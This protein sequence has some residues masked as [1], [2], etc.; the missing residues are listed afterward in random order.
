MAGG[1]N[2]FGGSTG[3]DLIPSGIL[4]D[5]RRQG[6]GIQQGQ[7]APGGIDQLFGLAGGLGQ[8]G[9][10]FLGGL[11]QAGQQLD[12]FMG[13]GFAQQQLGGLTNLINRN[14]SENQLP[15][16]QRGATASGTLG[17]GRQAVSEGIAMRGAN[18]NLFNFGGDLLQ[19]DLMR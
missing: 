8:Q 14:L 10:G 1:A 5:L 15:M 11:G 2:L 7:N 19:Q 13:S 4:A 6:Q 9:Q 17:G 16:L 3:A 18:E 12:Q